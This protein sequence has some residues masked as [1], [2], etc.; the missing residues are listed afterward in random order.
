M[1]DTVKAEQNIEEN[2]EQNQQQNVKPEELK[3]QKE[4]Q[5]S[6]EKE[7]QKPEEKGEKEEQKPIEEEF[8]CL[9]IGFLLPFFFAHSFLLFIQILAHKTPLLHVSSQERNSPKS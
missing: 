3:Q 1:S 4:D 8:D 7:Q 5:K 2:N 6:E 9:G